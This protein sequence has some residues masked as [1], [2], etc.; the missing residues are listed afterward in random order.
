[1][2]S[3]VRPHLEDRDMVS[4]HVRSSLLCQPLEVQFLCQRMRALKILIMFHTL[5]SR[6][7]ITLKKICF[8]IMRMYM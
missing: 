7:V 2:G 3:I 5:A 4:E 6:A 1:M 8:L